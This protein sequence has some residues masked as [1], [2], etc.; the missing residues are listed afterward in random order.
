MEPQIIGWNPYGSNEVAG[1]V[2]RDGQGQLVDASQ[3]PQNFAATEPFTLAASASKQLV[4]LN[5][6][7]VIRPDRIVFDRVQAASILVDNVTIGTT[8]LNASSGSA[9]ADAWAP[10]AVGTSMRCTVTASPN[11]SINF[12]L[13]N[14]T[15]GA[16]TNTSIVVIGPSL[17]A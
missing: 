12:Q 6:L 4:K 10:D 14:K 2:L 17:Q 5:V 15:A 1:D 8:S 16:L 11:L 13:S 7:R 3:L 9:P